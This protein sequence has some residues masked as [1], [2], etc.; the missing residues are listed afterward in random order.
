MLLQHDNTT[1][2]DYLVN[3]CN[4]HGCVLKGAC[5]QLSLALESNATKKDF[6]DALAINHYSRSLEKYALKAAT[7][8]TA[9]NTDNVY[10][11]EG[12]LDR[13]LGHI[14]DSRMLR[15]TCQLRQHLIDHTGYDYCYCHAWC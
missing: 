5:G 13:N 10:H 12:F 1:A 14:F 7:W 4:F 3:C 9:G 6:Y 11:V 8:E 15:Y 2:H